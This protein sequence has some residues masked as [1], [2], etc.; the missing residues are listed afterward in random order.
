MV[1]KQGDIIKLNFNPTKDHEQAG[2][3]PVL[4][5]SNSNYHK[6]SD[7]VVVLPITS[8]DRKYP[9]HIKMDART[10][11]K[12]FIMCEQIKSIDFNARSCK[13]VESLPSDILNQVLSYI[14]A[15]TKKES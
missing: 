11:T 3:R 12:G 15:I 2:F 8:T 13:I 7:L 5:I 6:Y 9:L 10:K 14:S 1:V 4:V